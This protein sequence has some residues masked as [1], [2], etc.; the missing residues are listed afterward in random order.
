MVRPD[1]IEHLELCIT[2]ILQEAKSRE[3]T[4][5]KTKHM[6]VEMFETNNQSFWMKV[7]NEKW[8]DSMSNR[9][10][11]SSLNMDEGEE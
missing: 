7:Y 8:L 1:T 11:A 4:I 10:M 2:Q 5:Q 6:I 3:W 9:D